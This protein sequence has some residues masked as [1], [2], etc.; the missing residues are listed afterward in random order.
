MD[1]INKIAMLL[2]EEWLVEKY[3]EYEGQ[4]LFMAQDIGVVSVDDLKMM[5]DYFGI[6]IEV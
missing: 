1:R 5:F 3:N 4:L 6:E 2:A